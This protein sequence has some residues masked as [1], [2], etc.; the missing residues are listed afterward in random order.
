MTLNTLLGSIALALLFTVP[1]QAAAQS[2]QD[3]SP[4]SPSPAAQ[5]RAARE[6]LHPSLTC[7]A[8]SKLESEA[9]SPVPTPA[10]VG[11][12]NRQ[13]VWS[14]EL[15]LLR[16][17]LSLLGQ[18]EPSDRRTQSSPLPTSPLEG[19]LP[20]TRSLTSSSASPLLVARPLPTTHGRGGRNFQRTSPVASSYSPN[21]PALRAAARA[22]AM[23]WQI[24]KLDDALTVASTKLSAAGGT[25]PRIDSTDEIFKQT[26]DNP[27][28]IIDMFV[29]NMESALRYAQ[30]L[31]ISEAEAILQ[32]ADT[33][34]RNDLSLLIPPN[35][36]LAAK[37]LLKTTLASLR[38]DSFTTA[39]KVTAETRMKEAEARVRAVIEAE[40]RAVHDQAEIHIMGANAHFSAVFSAF[41]TQLDAICPN[42]AEAESDIEPHPSSSSGQVPKDS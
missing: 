8:E 9:Q 29:G 41:H 32:K 21:S 14:S 30:T 5:V 28:K 17:Q 22:N 37:D 23:R 4:S 1:A 18:R 10:T 38:R 2:E 12:D 40:I 13:G 19:R 42:L 20:T 33:R 3:A 15:D 27:S 24:G 39:F 35:A 16:A 26:R 34:F 7:D 25:N 31:T 36:P 6:G 11:S